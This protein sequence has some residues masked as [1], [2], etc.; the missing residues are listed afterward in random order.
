MALEFPPAFRERVVP[1]LNS[2]IEAAGDQDAVIDVL[3]P[4]HDDPSFEHLLL[5]VVVIAFTESLEPLAADDDH[6]DLT[7]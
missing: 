6:L 7:A 4:H 2:L 3:R 1:I 5:G